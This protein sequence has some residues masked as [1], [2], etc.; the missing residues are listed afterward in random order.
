V[1]NRHFFVLT[2]VLAVVQCFLLR[3][4]GYSYPIFLILIAAAGL[5]IAIE[6]I[7]WGQRIFNVGSPEYFMEHSDQQE[8]NVH[9]LISERFSVKI[10]HIAAW[11]MFAYG[12]VFPIAAV[13]PSIRAFADKLQIVIPL[14]ILIPGFF[15]RLCLD[16]RPIFYGFGG[17]S[18]RILLQY[19]IIPVLDV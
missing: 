8:T 3:K 14:K 7:S 19:F 17:R 4:K 9:N 10:K 15:N 2:S 13:K 12:V 6:E 11:V 1:V 16:E 18:R 5:L